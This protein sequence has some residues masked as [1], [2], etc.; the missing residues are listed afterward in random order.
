MHFGA[1]LKHLE[2]VSYAEYVY[3]QSTH[4]NVVYEKILELYRVSTAT[5]AVATGL[6]SDARPPRCR[7]L[8]FVHYLL[9]MLS[10]S[11]SEEDDDGNSS[12]V[13]SGDATPNPRAAV[14]CRLPGLILVPSPVQLQNQQQTASYQQ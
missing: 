7:Q 3:T 12:S 5:I 9:P 11:S 10:D 14:E 13:S 6:K 2:Y 4:Q 1:L 8:N